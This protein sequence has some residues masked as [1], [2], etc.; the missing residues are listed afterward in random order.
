MAR[1]EGLEPEKESGANSRLFRLDRNCNVVE[2]TG[3]RSMDPNAG[4]AKEFVVNSEVCEVLT[5][6]GKFPDDE[7]LAELKGFVIDEKFED[8]IHRAKAACA[9]FVKP[10]KA[11]GSNTRSKS[12]SS[13]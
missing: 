1:L 6:T 5:S 12:K 11:D 4:N 3:F 9:S 13:R 8:I 7:K 2:I 10:G